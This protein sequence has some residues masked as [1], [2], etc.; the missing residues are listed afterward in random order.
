ML[1]LLL[2]SYILLTDFNKEISVL[3]YVLIGWVTTIMTEEFR[4]VNIIIYSILL[5][6]VFKN[7]KLKY[8]KSFWVV[9]MVDI[10]LCISYGNEWKKFIK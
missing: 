10:C 1:F 7:Q 2:Y 3:Q 8:I 5:L 4:Q 9:E 6:V